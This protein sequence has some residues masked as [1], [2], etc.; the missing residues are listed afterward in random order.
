LWQDPLKT[1]YSHVGTPV[2]PDGKPPSRE[3]LRASQEDLSRFRAHLQNLPLDVLID[4]ARWRPRQLNLMPGPLTIR[5]PIAQALRDHPLQEQVPLGTEATGR[6]LLLSVLQPGKA[7]PEDSENRVRSRYAVLA[8]LSAAGYAPRHEEHLHYLSIRLPNRQRTDP[9]FLLPYEEFRLSLI[10]PCTGS[11]GSGSDTEGKSD[12]AAA[13][14]R[15][16]FNPVVVLW[17]DQ[18]ALDDPILEGLNQLVEQIKGEQPLPIEHRLLGPTESTALMAML[19]KPAQPS[20]TRP[21]QAPGASA[22]AG[23]RF[24]SP[25]ATICSDLLIVLPGELITESKPS[26]SPQVKRLAVEADAAKIERTAGNQDEPARQAGQESPLRDTSANDPDDHVVCTSD[27]DR[28]P[29]TR[30]LVERHGIEIERT[31]STDDALVRQ[32]MVELHLRDAS[33]NDERNHVAL[34]GEWDTVYGRAW[35][36]TFLKALPANQGQGPGVRPIE[37]D[38]V[39]FLAYLRGIDGHVPQRNGLDDSTSES[40]GSNGSEGRKAPGKP[41]GRT[42]EGHAQTDYLRRLEARLARLQERLASRKSER[43]RAIG[44]VGSDVYDKLL[45]LRALRHRFSGAVFFTTDLD[46]R[47]LDPAER[48]YTRNLVVA[49][50]F[51]LELHADLQRAIPPFRGSYQTA[52]FYSCLA[53]IADPVLEERAR[54]LRAAGLTAPKPRVYE[55]GRTLA[56]DLG[57]SDA[58]GIHADSPTTTPW[59]LRGWRPLA[60]VVAVVC[61]LLLLWPIRS[62]VRRRSP[63]QDWPGRTVSSALIAAAVVVLVLFLVLAHLDSRTGQGEPLAFTQGISVW[64]TDALRLIA[65]LLSAHFLIRIM[66]AVRANDHAL[67]R[68]YFPEPSARKGQSPPASQPAPDPGTQQWRPWWARCGAVWIL[69]WENP[70]EPI[71]AKDLWNQYS[72]RS[73][74]RCRLLRT[75]LL[76]A[77]FY[78]FGGML[79]IIF[80]KPAEPGRGELC[81][82]CDKFILHASVLLFIYLLLFVLDATRLC[83]AFI[84]HLEDGEV[85]WNWARLEPPKPTEEVPQSSLANWTRFQVISRQAEVVGRFMYYP[86]VILLIMIISRHWVFDRWDWPI[87]LVLLF[88]LSSAGVLFAGWLLRHSARRVQG[89][90]LADLRS[91]LVAARAQPNTVRIGWLEQAITAIS[92]ERTGAF[93]PFTQDPVVAALLIP[94]GGYGAMELLI[95]LASRSPAGF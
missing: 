92:Q 19:A 73:R 76:T 12:C 46:V 58:Y 52:L 24:Y 47:L 55:I 51:G 40:A 20:L 27:H 60:A 30:L 91:E 9:P 38:N 29:P 10:T 63:D 59:I 75:L 67:Q 18:D 84:R 83:N 8:A 71:Q 68:R 87:S 13:G 42:A 57:R 17:I 44:V 77:P 39:H 90:T 34:I 62:A 2:S 1:V 89:R 54:Q 22:L 11:S 66:R 28:L 80:G 86:F 88:A 95:Q 82:T 33:P 79:I 43:I 23:A 65:A 26:A 16:V 32:L 37:P 69:G 94:T 41:P 6:P 74:F 72:Q 93:S 25:W 3:R 5:A 7:Y 64:T 48:K 50:P 31:T 56:Y 81:R 61:A 78:L 70:S 14:R 85:Q 49:S 45:V 36:W 15:V 4:A 35:R 21:E 53:A